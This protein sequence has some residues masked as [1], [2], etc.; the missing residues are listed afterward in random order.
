MNMISIY[1]VE[2]EDYG[3]LLALQSGRNRKFGK[4]KGRG[5]GIR[6]KI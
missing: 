5:G 2:W 1:L 6:R 4:G 3:I